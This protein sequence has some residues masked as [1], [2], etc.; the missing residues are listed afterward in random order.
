MSNQ[1]REIKES[2]ADALAHQADEFYEAVGFKRR[3]NSLR[4]TRKLSQ[5]TQVVE[6]CLE[7]S[8]IDNPDAA[9]AVYP[10]LTI[11]VPDVDSLVQQL[12]G[13]D[14][15]LVSSSSPTLNEPIEFVAPKGTGARWH[16][17]QPESVGPV[18]GEFVEFSR[19]WLFS[20]L[21]EYTSAS[22]VVTLFCQNDERVLFDQ[23]QFLRAVAAMILCGDVKL[24]SETLTAK[25]G[26]PGP[27]RIYASAFKYVE[28]LTS[29]AE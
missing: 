17:Y 2:V 23:S 28:R 19:S 26:R 16:I 27:R 29:R 21:N 4:Y 20:F 5:C 12:T 7:H 15:S 11:R 1:R 10:W 24:A 25:F 18:V 13:E 6:V 3:S 9:A 8:S 22:D 14:E